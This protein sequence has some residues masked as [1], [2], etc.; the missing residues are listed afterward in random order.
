ML[1]ERFAIHHV[2]IQPEV[3]RLHSSDSVHALPRCTSEIGHE[4]R[5]AELAAPGPREQ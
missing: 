1:H 3:K 5:N 4:H 2:T